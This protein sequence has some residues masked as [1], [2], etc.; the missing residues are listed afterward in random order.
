MNLAPKRLH[1]FLDAGPHIGGFDHG[2]QSLGG[3]NGLQ[4]G[5]AH[6]QDHDARGLD[7]AGG[8]HQ[9]G[10]QALVLVGSDHHGLVARNVGL[11]TRARPCSERA[12]CAA[13]LPARIR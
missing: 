2:A 1:L 3:G 10:K 4:A 7:R 8:G 9:H 11:R 13:R 6:A 5:N 12:W